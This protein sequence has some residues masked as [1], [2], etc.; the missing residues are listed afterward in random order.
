MESI[1]CQSGINHHNYAIT[2]MPMPSKRGNFPVLVT[3]GSHLLQSRV[4]LPRPLCPKF[5]HLWNSVVQSARQTMDVE[6]ITPTS[7]CWSLIKRFRPTI[8]PLHINMV[9]QKSFMVA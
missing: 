5:A 2:H 9:S 7:K 1:T 3:Y 8:V 6:V 4:C